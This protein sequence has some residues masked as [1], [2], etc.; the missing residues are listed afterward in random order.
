MPLK[1]YEEL[2]RQAA[3]TYYLSGKEAE[4][5]DKLVEQGLKDYKNGKC[6]EAS[7]L[8]EALKKY[9]QRHAVKKKR[10]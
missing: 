5:L 4:A 8:E 9:E 7:S 6:I 2:R 10:G 1:E 3:P